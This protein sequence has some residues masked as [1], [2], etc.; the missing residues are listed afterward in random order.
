MPLIESA[1]F[2]LYRRRL[3]PVKGKT[4]RRG[5]PELIHTSSIKEGEAWSRDFTIP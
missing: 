4:F 1:L 5:S 2:F 3:H